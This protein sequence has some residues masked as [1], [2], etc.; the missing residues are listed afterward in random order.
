MTAVI[1]PIDTALLVAR[2][3][4]TASGPFIESVLASALGPDVGRA[5]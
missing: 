4:C 5:A 2:F 1:D 3:T